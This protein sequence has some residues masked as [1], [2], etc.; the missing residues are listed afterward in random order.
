MFLR[1]F[2]SLILLIFTS[3]P[4]FAQEPN[5]QLYDQFL[6]RSITKKIVQ[7]IPVNYVNYSQIVKDKEFSNLVSQIGSYPIEKLTSKNEKLAFYINAYNILAI[8]VIKQHWPIKS[9]KE[10]GSWFTPVWN[11]TA[12]KIN[13][14]KTSLD[15]IE[16]KI[17]RKLGE[18]RIHFAI[19]CA[20]LSCPDL[21]VEA[22]KAALLNS[23][24]TDQIKI[25]LHNSKKG[26]IV[27]GSTAKSSKIFKWFSED[28]DTS[29]GVDAFI[30]HSLPHIK[31][32]KVDPSLPYNW[33]LNGG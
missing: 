6:K 26:F 12:G 19:V 22:Y 27:M 15:A 9:I 7:G 1:S 31:F 11:K 2:F 18:P 21:R 5:W 8:N 3:P 4:S 25:F 24:L 28:F 29:D 23:Q 16:N 30:H 14:R 17:L 32:N 20:S 13:G 33:S 10:A